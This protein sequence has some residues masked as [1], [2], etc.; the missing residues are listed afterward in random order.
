MLHLSEVSYLVLENLELVGGTANGL[1]IDD[2]ATADTPSHHV[3]LRDLDVHDA[4]SGGNNDC[5]KLSGLDD[6]FI[7]GSRI[8]HCD[9]GDMIDHVGC[10]RGL[11]HGN[12]FDGTPGSG[13]IQMKGGS[14]DIVVHGNHFL[15]VDGRAINAGGSTGLEFFRPIDAPYEAARLT[16]VA[17]VFERSG[18]DSIV[19]FVGCD[20]CVFANNT[21][22]EPRGWLARVLQ[23]STDARFVPSRDGLFVNNLIVFRVA[24]VRANEYNVGGGTAPETFTFGSN[25]WWALDD[26]SFPGPNA[27]GAGIT[28]AGSI[29]GADP[30]V[31]SS[32]LYRP[33]LTTPVDGAGRARPGPSADF[34]GACFESPPAIGAHEAYD[35]WI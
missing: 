3:V 25:L 12:T 19:A 4:G 14:A 27:D 6:Y 11:I 18:S 17:N 32:D 13:G 33:C 21:I 7:L 22:S 34:G 30:G 8:A 28:E 20:A 1:N 24:D 10:H 9:G 26:A 23:E 15:D 2:G 35:C 16:I 5:I 29:V 31:Q